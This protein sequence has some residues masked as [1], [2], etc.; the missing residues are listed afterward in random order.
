MKNVRIP[1]VSVWLG[2]LALAILVTAAVKN[3]SAVKRL[4]GDY[5]ALTETE[6][7]AGDSAVLMYDDG[8]YAQMVRGIDLDETVADMRSTVDSFAREALPDLADR[9][10]AAGVLYVMAACAAGALL[11]CEQS[12]ENSLKQVLLT[13]SAAAGSYLLFAAILKGA[14][15]VYRVPFPLPSREASKMLVPSL[16]SVMGGSCALGLMLRKIKYKKT[17]AVLAI[18]LVFVLFLVG[19]GIE[20][21][22]YSPKTVSSFSYV[23]ELVG[24]ENMGGYYYDEEKNAVVGNGQ[25]FP[26]EIVPNPEHTVGAKRAAGLGLTVINPYSGNGLELLRQ[27]LYAGIPLWAVLLHIVKSVFWIGLAALVPGKKKAR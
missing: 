17:A 27:E 25:E 15:A 14:A 13:V 6:F 3:C 20:A 23:V 16:L 4:S 22:L 10:Y 5:L 26:P 7:Q 1:R 2:L 21:G 8:L 19:T 9:A 12:R 18:P 11:I 24:E